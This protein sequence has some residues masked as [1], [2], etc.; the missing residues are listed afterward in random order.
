MTDGASTAHA[1]WGDG[2]A[3]LG[4]RQ[5]GCDPRR[6]RAAEIGGVMAEIALGAGIG[7]ISADPRLGD[8]K[9]D[10]HDAALAPHLFD[11]EG[12]PC[13]GALPR[14]ATA[15]PQKG[16][17]RGLLADR[18]SAADPAPRRIA[19]HRVL[20]RVDIEPAV[21]AKLAVLG[22]DR[23][24]HHVAVHA[25]EPHPVARR[26]APRRHIAHHRRGDRRVDE[27]VREHPQHRQ[28]DQREHQLDDELYQP[29]DDPALPLTL[30]LVLRDAVCNSPGHAAA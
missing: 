6:F 3:L 29:P 2:A 22:A 4:K 1:A 19:L 30:A 21:R 15:L 25:V 16:V 5:D 11:Q 8:V 18:R 14:I 17:L 24:A 23:G 28:Q 9:I 26:P 20:D 10:F 7:A 13:F 12:E 27:A